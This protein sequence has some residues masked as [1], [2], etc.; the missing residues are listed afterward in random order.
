MRWN[1]VIVH[2]NSFSLK[3]KIESL[4]KRFLDI[5]RYLYSM[6]DDKDL[7]LICVEKRRNAFLKLNDVDFLYHKQKSFLRQDHDYFILLLSFGSKR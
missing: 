1:S 3:K 2:L 4:L 7:K 6:K 5:E